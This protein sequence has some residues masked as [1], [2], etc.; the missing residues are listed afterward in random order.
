MRRAPRRLRSRALARKALGP[1]LEATGSVQ[2]FRS[3]RSRRAPRGKGPGGGGT[4]G[5]G[6]AAPVG[7]PQL[8]GALALASV[9]A[10]FFQNHCCFRGDSDASRT[11]ASGLA[12]AQG[13]QRCDDVSPAVQQGFWRKTLSGLVIDVSVLFEG[14]PQERKNCSGIPYHNT[15][16]KVSLGTHQMA[17]E[18]NRAVASSK[19][20]L[21]TLITRAWCAL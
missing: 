3:Q 11:G 20:G 18:N 9:A 12:R 2:S 8:L 21:G 17:G 7:Q 4:D 15:I 6:W 19:L 10:V 1:I 5:L 16:V 14:K 13:L